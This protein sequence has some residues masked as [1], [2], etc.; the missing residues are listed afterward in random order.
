MSFYVPAKGISNIVK[1]NEKYEI[2]N[3][4]FGIVNIA[5]TWIENYVLVS[6]CQYKS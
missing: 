5:D 4:S 3:I 2:F 6:R 1:L